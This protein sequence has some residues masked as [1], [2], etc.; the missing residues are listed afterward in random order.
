MLRLKGEPDD[1][2]ADEP[3]RDVALEEEPIGDDETDHGGEADRFGLLSMLPLHGIGVAAATFVPTFLAVFFG[4][5]YL[6]GAVTSARTPGAPTAVATA[7]PAP[8]MASGP[9]WTPSPSET[10]RGGPADRVVP[11]PPPVAA[12]SA[13]APQVPDTTT[14]VLDDPGPREREQPRDPASP[15][16]A[17]PATAVEPAPAT[18]ARPPASSPRVPEPQRKAT[19]SRPVLEP[20]SVPEPRQAS[21]SPDARTRSDAGRPAGD[22]TPA[23]AFADR[24]AASRLASSIERQGY[25]VEI[26]QDG[27]ST[28]PW[29]V[30]IGSQ[31]SG[32]ARRR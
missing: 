22:W 32:G 27:S 26:R 28:R 25:P 29:V 21:A 19:A 20:R 6:L 2:M 9:A 7:P 18:P 24:D 10:L 17:P 16:P 5:P 14:R 11:P 1:H 8:G 12:P 31:P 13:S 23:A 30:W 4:L 3:G 15:T